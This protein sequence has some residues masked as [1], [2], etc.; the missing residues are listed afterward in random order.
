MMINT[1]VPTCVHLN[2]PLLV[3][4]LFRG[5]SSADN[6]DVTAVLLSTQTLSVS[7]S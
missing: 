1:D 4:Q 6:D 5:T 2:P 3:E 7:R